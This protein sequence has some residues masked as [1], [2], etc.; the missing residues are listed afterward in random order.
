M[1]EI[2]GKSAA[3]VTVILVAC[4]GFHLYTAVF[5]VFATLLHRSIHLAF[6]LPLAFL[7]Y[8]AGKRSPMDRPSVPDWL[9]ASLALLPEL[10]I[11]LDFERI[12]HRMEHL[13]PLLNQEII[14]GALAVTMVLEATRRCVSKVLTLITLTCIVYILFGHYPV[15]GFFQHP[16]IQ[17]QRIIEQL[18]LLAEQGVH[19]VVVGV[20]ATYVYL[21]VL[22]GAFLLR[23]EVGNYIIDLSSALFGK[24]LGGPAKVAVVS[25]CL[26]GSISG[27]G[28]ANVYATGSFTIPLMKKLGY[29][30]SFAAAVESAS[31]TGGQYMPPV[32]GAVGFIIA[33]VTGT[34]YYEVCRQAIL[35]ALLFYFAIFSIVH[36]EAKKLGL[37]GIPKSELKSAPY[38]AKKFYLF[39]PIVLILVMIIMRYT[40]FL[41][42]F[43]AIC[44]AFLLSFAEPQSRLYPRRLVAT[45]AEGSKNAIMIAVACCCVGIVAASVIYTGVGLRL[46]SL[47]M[48]IAKHS[49]YLAPM[50]TMLICIAL[51]MGVP[52]VPAYVV[53]GVI[54]LPIMA[55]LGFTGLGPHLF[56]LYYAVIASVTPPVAISA[57]A[58]ASIAGANPMKSAMMAA[59][60]AFVGFIV[61]F[62]FLFNN[63]L[64]LLGNWSDIILSVSLAVAVVF[65]GALVFIGYLRDKLTAIGRILCFLVCAVGIF[66][67]LVLG[68]A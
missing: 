33:E 40:P 41:A 55:K 4:A 18:Y 13:T 28:P 51:G 35:S 30:P 14:L 37:K 23:T 67:L 10:F 3:V 66:L 2:K 63:A 44:L 42:A 48:M 50:L 12:N 36:L 56:I 43:Y 24:S 19:G 11:I 5:G 65:A 6:F 39:T 38:L 20:S 8:P 60:V 29:R 1:R 47:V 45:L 27:S 53:T 9:L 15:F 54:T 32:M 62:L 68:K 61:P 58:A 16:P 7:F 59:R 64:L 52:C 31:S 57:Y 22:F 34:P 26:F 25:S 17:F 21:F 46:T 49:I